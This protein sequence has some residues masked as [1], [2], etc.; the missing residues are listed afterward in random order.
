MSLFRAFLEPQSWLRSPSMGGHTW[1]T[2]RLTS[3]M[4]FRLAEIE[5]RSP[6]MGGSN[7]LFLAKVT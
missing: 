2:E 5:L 7:Y 6:V 1:P 4:P 3:S